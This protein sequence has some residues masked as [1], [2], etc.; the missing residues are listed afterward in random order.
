MVFEREEDQEV[1]LEVS[2]TFH[3][4]A[5]KLA[6]TVTFSRIEPWMFETCGGCCFRCDCCDKCLENDSREF[7]RIR[8]D[9]DLACW[10]WEERADESE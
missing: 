5:S 1:G 7:D 4:M 3:K 6:T 2:M 10:A 8:E 9:N